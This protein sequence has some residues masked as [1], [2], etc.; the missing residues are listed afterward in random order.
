LDVDA[1]L[2][3]DGLNR[4]AIAG[5]LDDILVFQGNEELA[6]MSERAKVYFIYLHHLIEHPP[7]LARHASLRHI[8]GRRFFLPPR[9]VLNPSR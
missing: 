2:S 7:E 8:D 6:A 1:S 4:T 9:P 3:P 5:P